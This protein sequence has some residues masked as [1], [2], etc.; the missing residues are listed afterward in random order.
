MINLSDFQSKFILKPKSISL[1]KRIIKFSIVGLISTIIN[2]SL[3]FAIYSYLDAHYNLASSLGYI[4]GLF[5]GYVLNKYWTFNKKLTPGRT[6]VLKYTIAQYI[7]LIVCQIF[8]YL[9]VEFLIFN[10]LLANIF[11]LAIAAI[12]S[13]LLIEFFV[14]NS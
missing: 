13:Y 7:G 10:P 12:I 9:L 6:Y 1:V 8:L 2:Y 5:F 14:F 3:F 11:S 4:F